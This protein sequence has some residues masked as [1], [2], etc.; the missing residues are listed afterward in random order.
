MNT[1]FLGLGANIGNKEKQLEQAIDQLNSHDH[2]EVTQIADFKSFK[3][4]LPA[5]FV[6]QPD[7]L[8]T[9][10]ECMTLLSPEELFEYT[11]KIEISL[12]RQSKGDFQ[13][14]SIDI[15]ILF[16]NQDIISKDTL[17]I[18]HARLHERVFVLQP[19]MQIAPYF[20]HPVFQKTI[21]ELY[22][23]QNDHTD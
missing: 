4:D 14:R 7:Y 18:P 1:I 21:K 5:K 3:A 17:I 8:N 6:S 19:M 16:Y 23:E 11:Q 22:L 15:D 2:L 12:G 10:I 20:M 9:V 13:P